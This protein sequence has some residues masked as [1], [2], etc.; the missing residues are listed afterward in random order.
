MLAALLPGIQITY[1]GEEIAQENGYV[2]FEQGKDPIACKTN[3]TTYMEISRD[4]ERT[5]F[6]WDKTKNAGFSEADETWLPVSERYLENNL[7]DQS[8][9]DYQSHYRV[10]QELMQLR[11]QPTFIKG[12]LK[13][14]AATNKVVAFSR[15]LEGHDTYVC[16]FNMGDTSEI[17]NLT[18]IFGFSDVYFEVAV[19]SV[20]SQFKKRLVFLC[21]F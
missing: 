20:D 1:S 4:F 11:K 13:L 14:T 16:L 8:D 19:V 9:T 17:L 12:K 6:H 10:Y 3:E 7:E 15:T 5:P 21:Q 2:T 18:D